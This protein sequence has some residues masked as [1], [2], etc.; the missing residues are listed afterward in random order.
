MSNKLEES[1]LCVYC[2]LSTASGSGRWVNRVPADNGWS[3]AECMTSDCDRCGKPIA[4]DEDVTA[5]DVFK[6]NEHWGYFDDGSF[7]VHPECLT[8]LELS[9]WEKSIED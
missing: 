9:R 6:L 7:C 8:A 2:L 3:C 4:L 5:Y 1:D